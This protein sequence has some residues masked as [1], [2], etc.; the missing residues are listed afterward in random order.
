MIVLCKVYIK[1]HRYCE[2]NILF[3][4]ELGEAAKKYQMQVVNY[5]YCEH[6]NC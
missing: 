5:K 6:Q 1:W 4:K 2:A 3:I